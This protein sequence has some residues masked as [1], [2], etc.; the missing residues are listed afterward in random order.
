M[1]RMLSTMLLLESQVVQTAAELQ[2]VHPT[3]VELQ[4]LQIPDTSTYPGA[5][6]QLPLLITL[7]WAESQVVHALEL[8][9]K[10]HPSMS[11]PQPTQRL[12]N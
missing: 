1:L 9:H 11:V 7:N 2:A 5:H 10:L 6:T 12:L 3:S 8:E 4:A